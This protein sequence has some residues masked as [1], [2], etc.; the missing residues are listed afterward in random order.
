MEKLAEAA[1]KLDFDKIRFQYYPAA[2]W[3]I[4]PL[5]TLSLKQF[6]EA[7]KNPTPKIME[8]FDKIKKAAF[9]GDLKTK[10]ELKQNNLY[11]F[12]PSC[13]MQGGRSYEHIVDFLPLMVVEFDKI[14]YAEELKQELFTRLKCCIAAYLS[15]SR[16]GCKFIIRIPKPKS[17]EEYKEYYC[18]MA[19]YL[20][21]FNN[22]D[23]ANFNIA[24]PLF[25]SHD[26][27]I[28]IREDAEEWTTRGGKSNAFKPYE[29]DF[30]AP[31]DV[32]DK[33]KG[34]VISLLTHLFS[35]IED[36]GHGQVVR[37]SC[38]LG[39]MVASNYISH[40]EAFELLGT[41]IEG[42]PY[43]AKGTRGYLKTADTMLRN[44]LGSP[45]LL[46]RHKK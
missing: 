6:L 18:G 3:K 31:D 41:L 33:D 12:L 21:K 25:I 37:Y 9:E 19:Y 38:L 29:G 20:E 39:G 28:L 2:V 45:I 42:N 8:V 13:V 35:K 32:N 4:D 44:G 16:R 46:D 17:I 43:L 30:E 22:F 15:P 1:D 23:P 34:E 40:E 26:K 10:D 24:L 36:N 14:E 11:Y 27:D 7:H 5:G